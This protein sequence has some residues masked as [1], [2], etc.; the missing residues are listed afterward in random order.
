MVTELLNVFDTFSF[1]Y[2]L[3]S[4]VKIAGIG[5][6]KENILNFQNNQNCKCVE[7]LKNET[8]RA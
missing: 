5:I 6:I 3:D 4:D 2:R 7:N 1:L 8:V